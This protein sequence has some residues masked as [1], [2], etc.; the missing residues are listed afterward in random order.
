MGKRSL[1]K[2]LK[3]V[4]PVAMLSGIASRDK[5]NSRN[6]DQRINQITTN[7][8][9][10]Y[11]QQQAQQQESFN[12]QLSL[13]SQ[14]AQTQQASARTQQSLL[15]EATTKLRKENSDR[16]ATFADTQNKLKKSQARSN[17]SRVRGGIFGEGQQQPPTQLN[18]RLG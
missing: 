11:Q 12:Q 7:Q 10:L 18:S 4:S 14:Q 6:M 8:Q 1:G 2:V 5:K 3:A 15:A 9:S 16:Q 13:Q 17:R